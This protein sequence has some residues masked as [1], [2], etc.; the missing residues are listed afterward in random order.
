MHTHVTPPKAHINPLVPVILV[1]FINI[2]TAG[3]IEPLIGVNAFYN[4]SGSNV[5]SLPSTIFGDFLSIPSINITLPAPVSYIEVSNTLPP[6]TSTD[7]GSFYGAS[8]IAATQDASVYIDALRHWTNF[9][10]TFAGSG[11]YSLTV[12]AFTP[13]LGPQIQAGVARGGNAIDPPLGGYVAVQLAEQTVT[14]APLPPAGA[15]EGKLLLLEQYVFF[16]GFTVDFFC[17]FFD[18]LSIHL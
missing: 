12:L 1:T 13:V 10:E 11:G 17:F 3:I 16:F 5:S 18:Q 15:E 4:I 8:A 2:I 14:G 6:G 7:S 9:T